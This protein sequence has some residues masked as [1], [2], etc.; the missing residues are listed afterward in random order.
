MKTT[1]LILL[2]LLVIITFYAVRSW[3]KKQVELELKALVPPAPPNLVPEKP[4]ISG[5]A[6]GI[7]MA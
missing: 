1:E 6:G 4:V 2:V 3:M 5:F 7:V